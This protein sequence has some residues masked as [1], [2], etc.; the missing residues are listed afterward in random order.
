MKIRAAAS[1]AVSTIQ[2]FVSAVRELRTLLHNY[3]WVKATFI[4]LCL[5]AFASAAFAATVGAAVLGTDALACAHP[6]ELFP[7]LYDSVASW[8][9]WF[10]TRWSFA[11]AVVCMA[12]SMQFAHL[13]QLRTVIVVAWCSLPQQ[14]SWWY[15]LLILP[16]CS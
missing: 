4:G 1:A 2:Q 7:E 10:F 9:L 15:G 5:W 3:S 13:T 8:D 16:E 6:G 14:A 11:A 12:V